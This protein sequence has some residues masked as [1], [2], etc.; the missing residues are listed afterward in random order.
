MEERIMKNYYVVAN[1]ESYKIFKKELEAR[2]YKN[3]LEDSVL[4]GF[5]SKNKAEN[6]A[7]NRLGKSKGIF[8]IVINGRVP[9]I[10][11]NVEDMKA[12]VTGFENAIVARAKTIEEANTV[13]NSAMA[14]SEPSNQDY[15]VAGQA[16]TVKAQAERLQAKKQNKGLDYYA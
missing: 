10:Y 13:I 14:P 3:S 11:N 9:G 4:K 16:K 1:K 6:W 7:K 8:F 15:K 12:Q 2:S 5:Y